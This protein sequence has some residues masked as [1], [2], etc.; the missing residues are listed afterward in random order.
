MNPRPGN[1]AE[2][3]W[4]SLTRMRQITS[5]LLVAATACG[6]SQKPTTPPP[7]LPE[8]KPTAEPA[9]P[10]PS[11]EKP[12]EP[13]KPIDMTITSTKSSVK[14]VSAGKGKKEA[15]KLTP[16]QGAKQQ[17][18]IALDVTE[19]AGD[20]EATVP[21]IVL[22]GE[23]EV[24]NVDGSGAA[25][26]ELTVNGTDARDT[27]QQITGDKF[28]QF[29]D[30][31]GA[32]KGLVLSGTIDAHGGGS[33]IKV[34][35][36][37]PSGDVAGAIQLLE[38]ALPS[39]PALP[40]EAVGVGAKWQATRA[41]KVADKLDSTETTDYELVAHKGNTWTIKGTTKVSG[42]DQDV[43][44]AK[45]SSIGGDGKVEV[46]LVDGVLAPSLNSSVSTTFTATDPGKNTIQLTLRHGA[47]ITP[48]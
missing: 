15:L 28:Q 22:L 46:A 31:L 17:L 48:K 32:F 41:V 2:R 34:H 44:G 6:G 20:K 39:W 27:S 18:E 35:M 26:Y 24:K 5:V 19:K 13:P 16:K 36:D 10:D 25:D 38:L 8:A 14:L 33:D 4:Y 30:G 11:A 23:L 42:T 40:N 7:P 1:P 37:K 43:D 47:Q 45:I 9:K 29:K 3:L 21:T 12:P